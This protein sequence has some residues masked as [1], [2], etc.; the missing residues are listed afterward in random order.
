MSRPVRV[1]LGNDH[2]G[3]PLRDVVQQVVEALGGSIPSCAGP[4]T[5]TDS[6]DYPD[7]AAS[8]AARV[9]DD[10]QSFGL[11]ICGTGQGVAMTANRFAGVRAGVVADTFSARMLREHNDANV[12]CL[13]ARV[14]GPGLAADIVRTFLATPFSG[15]ARHRRRIEKIQAQA[16]SAKSG[17]KE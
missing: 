8:V 7:V 4:E 16:D 9:V 15:D 13:G 12:L 10:P 14:V 11:L 17:A 5:A 1:H 3:V 2:G 6:V